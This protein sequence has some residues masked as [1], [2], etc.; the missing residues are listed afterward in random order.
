MYSYFARIFHI[1]KIV[2]LVIL[3]VRTFIL[4][5]GIVNG[6]SMEPTYFD[7]RFFWVNKF[8]LLFREPRFGDIVIAK[9][10]NVD[11]LIVKRIIGVEGDRI[12]IEREGVFLQKKEGNRQKLE[13]IYLQKGVVTKSQNGKPEYF[14]SIPKD[15]YFLMGDNRSMSI[16]SRKFGFI[17]RRDIYGVIIRTPLF[18]K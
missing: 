11:K 8:T 15:S 3:C 10:P 5:P 1:I 16:D 7:D 2:V 18:K 17:H 9:E 13:E 12:S 14:N 6:R 4:E